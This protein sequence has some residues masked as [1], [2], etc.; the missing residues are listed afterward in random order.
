[1]LIIYTKSKKGHI[2]VIP[3]NWEGGTSPLCPLYPY[4]YD[5]PGLEALYQNT[6][7]GFLKTLHKF[8]TRET[9]MP[10]LLFQ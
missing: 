9:P 8:C 2:N 6:K 5:N 4:R 10:E 7:K 3:S 1:M